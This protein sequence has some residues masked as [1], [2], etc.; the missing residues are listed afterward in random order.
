[1]TQPLKIFMVVML[2]GV[3][4]MTTTNVSAALTASLERERI[5]AGETVQLLIETDRRVSGWLDTRELE[6]DF[7]ILGNVSGSQVNIINGQ[8]NVK[9]IWTITLS[10]R[11]SGKLTIPSLEIA[12]ERSKTLTLQVDETPSTDTEDSGSVMFIETEM[13]RQ[14]PY[15]QGMVLYTARLYYRAKLIEGR[16]SE[17]E[18]DNALVYRIG[19]DQEFDAARDG[20]NYRVVERQYAIFPQTSGKLVLSAPV[21]DARIAENSPLNRNRLPDFFGG[22]PLNNMFTVTRPVR[23]RGKAEVLSVQPRPDEASGSGWLPAEQIELIENWNPQDGAVHVG[24]PLKRTVII[25]AR[26][27][28]GEQ[29]PDLDPNNVDGFKV[30]PDQ[31]KIETK[32]LQHTIEGEKTRSTAFVP[33]QAGRLTLPAINLHWWDTKN[34]QSRVAQLPERV[35]EILPAVG[36]DNARVQSTETMAALTDNAQSSINNETEVQSSAD[37]DAFFDQ[38]NKST[39]DFLSTQVGIWFWISLLLALLWLATIGLWWRSKR[40]QSDS[41][42]ETSVDTTNQ[43]YFHQAKK[44]FQSACKANEPRMA[45]RRLLEWS[46]IHWLD[47]PPQGLDDLA[48]R[49]ADPKVRAALAELD[50]SLYHGENHPWDGRQLAR[51][52]TKFPQ[53]D[54]DRYEKSMLPDL[55]T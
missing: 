17:P 28:T 9:T 16:L 52:M 10:P 32:D 18:S 22:D 13:D 31:P 34:N 33:I 11:H 27:V 1:M 21:L 26:G 42:S 6:Q 5:S 2:S 49:I 19:E 39:A 29:L 7:D 4:C 38:Q 12:G 55:Y 45:R 20:Y 44:H 48:S 36:S 46:A 40:H 15:V 24:D 30:Y 50:R 51:L 3:F 25:R 35:V 47:D 43:E 8:I 54:R 14:D 23:I 53:R 37:G 41:I